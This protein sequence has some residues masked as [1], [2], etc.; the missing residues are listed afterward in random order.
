[1][2]PFT[3]ELLPIDPIENSQAVCKQEDLKV[4]CDDKIYLNAP[5]TFPLCSSDTHRVETIYVPFGTTCEWTRQ[6]FS[7]GSLFNVTVS[8]GRGTNS[9]L[10]RI[11]NHFKEYSWWIVPSMCVYDALTRKLGQVPWDYST[12]QGRAVTVLSSDDLS[13]FLCAL[14]HDL[15]LERYALAVM[16]Q[17]FFLLKAN[18]DE[19]QCEAIGFAEDESKIVCN[20]E[21][22]IVEYTKGEAIGKAWIPPEISLL[23]DLGE[24]SK[25]CVCS[26]VDS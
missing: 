23:S 26:R 1:M 9:S 14:E 25:C 21:K 10:I 7:Y 22:R 15:V 16:H 11:D 8:Y 12:P 13:P 24:E 6:V 20:A 2:L 5:A 18:W 17:M 19:D 3:I 4:V